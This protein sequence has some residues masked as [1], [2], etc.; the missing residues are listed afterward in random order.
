MSRRYKKTLCHGKLN[1]TLEELQQT[2]GHYV[3]RFSFCG[4]ETSNAECQFDFEY[5]F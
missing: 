4:W 3:E 1:L 2:S 5:A